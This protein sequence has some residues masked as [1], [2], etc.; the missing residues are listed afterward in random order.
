MADQPYVELNDG[1][2]MPQLGLGV[3]QTAAEDAAKV[4][5]D[6]LDAGYLA[7]DTATIYRNEEGVG[8]AIAGRDCFLT[9]KLWNADQGYD[10]ALKAFETSAKKLKRDSIDLYLIHWAAPRR[11]TYRESWKALCRLKEEGRAISI[12]VSN[13]AE[14]HLREIIDDTGVAPV[15]NQI[16]L[17]PDFQQ[18]E[19]RAV[20]DRLDIRT[21]SWSPL[22]QAK[23]IA[24]PVLKRIGEKH[25]KSPA[26]VIIRWHLD[27]GLV[28]IPKSANPERLRQ[29]LD[30]FDFTLDGDDMA[31]IG[32]L[33]RKDGRMGPDPITIDA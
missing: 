5:G 27:S 20:D 3:W 7:V 19:M 22:G 18:R 31:E 30:V 26:Q 6:A 11:N 1:R 8:E 4:V 2:R 13:F 23:A 28:V 21:Q 15:L 12:G 29:N 9:T 10:S 17:H 24:N 32:K 16:E 25:G 33:D 14:E